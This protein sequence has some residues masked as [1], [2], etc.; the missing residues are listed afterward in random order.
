MPLLG[1][2][3]PAK[4][5]T[6]HS[7]IRRK[8]PQPPEQ[9]SECAVQAPI[10]FPSSSTW[11]ERNFHS[12]NASRTFT[13]LVYVT[14]VCHNTK[15]LTFLFIGVYLS[16]NLRLKQDPHFLYYTYAFECTEYS[17]KYAPIIG[18]YLSTVI[19]T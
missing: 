10:V 12:E 11:I 7:R 15:T 9:V 13:N 4:R 3:R 17:M 19:Q 8:I 2:P 14:S 6:L 1:C 16:E 18:V 5:T